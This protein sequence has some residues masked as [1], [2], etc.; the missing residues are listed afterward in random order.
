MNYNRAKVNLRLELNLKGSVLSWNYN[1]GLYA[2]LLQS[3]RNPDLRNKIHNGE[4]PRAFVFSNLIPSSKDLKMIRKSVSPLG[5]TA[6]YKAH[7]YF[8]SRDKSVFSEMIKGF[9]EM[10][11]LWLAGPHGRVEYNIENV[12]ME[13]VDVKDS[14]FTFLSPLVVRNKDGKYVDI[15]EVGKEGIEEEINKGL[16]RVSKQ[17][18]VP[19]DGNVRII[20]ELK[21][22]LYHIHD[23]PVLAYIPKTKKVLEIEGELTKAAALYLGLGDKTHLG[24]GMVGL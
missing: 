12:I 20:G 7:F 11:K 18:G 6:P 8:T 3:I 17:I 5:M 16:E 13:N 23:T 4:L 24:F 21:K 15:E 19:L 9:T 22:K 10:S 1:H 2:V 14:V